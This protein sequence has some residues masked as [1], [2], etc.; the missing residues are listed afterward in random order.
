MGTVVFV[1]YCCMPPLLTCSPP[2]SQL[3]AA[4]R[5][6]HVAAECHERALQQHRH[7]AAGAAT[8]PATRPVRAALTPA[9]LPVWQPGL[10]Q[11]LHH[12]E[13]LLRRGQRSGGSSGLGN[14]L[15]NSHRLVFMWQVCRKSQPE[16][17]Q[18]SRSLIATFP[19]LPNNLQTV[20]GWESSSHK[21]LC[22]AYNKLHSRVPLNSRC[23]IRFYLPLLLY[24]EHVGCK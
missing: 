17:K 2:P 20:F 22:L 13:L 5:W 8:P 16:S 18:K 4:L 10:L 12:E 7:P 21:M 15:V 6:Q 23:S 9:Q 24:L 11:L 14:T 3:T 19:K 1:L